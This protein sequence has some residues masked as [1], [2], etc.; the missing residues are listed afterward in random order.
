MGKYLGEAAVYTTGTVLSC[1]GHVV[2]FVRVH[3]ASTCTRLC[4]VCSSASELFLRCPIH[5]QV[6]VPGRI[7]RLVTSIHP[8]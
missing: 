8:Y 1:S 3:V 5:C 2:L 7:D 6:L 4:G